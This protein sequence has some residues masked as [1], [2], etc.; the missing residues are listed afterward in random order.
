[1]NMR[2]SRFRK[3]IVTVSDGERSSSLQQQLDEHQGQCPECRE[4]AHQV[5]SVE[6]L[7]RSMPAECAP[8]AFSDRLCQR[9]GQCQLP[10][11]VP[12]FRWLPQEL[13]PPAPAIH[14]RAGFAAIAALVILLS[15]GGLFLRSS[16]T[17]PP[18]GVGLGSPVVTTGAED[19]RVAETATDS[20]GPL[21][22]EFINQHR[23][24]E[25]QRPL[26]D[27][28]GLELVSYPLPTE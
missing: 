14:L 6:L 20:A 27:D 28:P 24:Y 25:R 15:V 3:L 11:S 26:A 8:D 10:K 12:W 17:M 5:R 13:R 23:Q 18:S 1:M 9:L 2:C 22:E 4:Y 7:L 19:V 21:W 16:A